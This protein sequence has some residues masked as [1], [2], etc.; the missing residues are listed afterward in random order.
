MAF[1]QDSRCVFFDAT[2][3]F[4]M[5]CLEAHVKSIQGVWDVRVGDV[6]NQESIKPAQTKLSFLCLHKRSV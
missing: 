4:C 6:T 1:P 3:T 5:I 2:G